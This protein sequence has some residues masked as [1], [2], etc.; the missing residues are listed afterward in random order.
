MLALE[1]EIIGAA[2]EGAVARFADSFVRVH[3]L[4][5]YVRN[6]SEGLI[7]GAVHPPFYTSTLSVDPTK[8][9]AGEGVP[10]RRRSTSE[11]PM[12]DSVLTSHC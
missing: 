8:Q 3:H 11:R 7:A 5:A 9:K 2:R 4:T 10:S 12:T 1:N 6:G